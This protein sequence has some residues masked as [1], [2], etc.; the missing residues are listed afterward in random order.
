[1]FKVL[2]SLVLATMSMLLLCAE[3]A[4]AAEHPSNGQPINEEVLAI[5]YGGDSFKPAEL[6]I[7][8]VVFSDATAYP[9]VSELS[10]AEKYMLAGVTSTPWKS[11]IQLKPWSL[12]VYFLLSKYYQNGMPI[13][14]QL[15]YEA[16]RLLPEYAKV[17]DL[18]LDVYRNPMT[19]E[20]P[21]LEDASGLP[22]SVYVHELTEDEKHHLAIRD[23][24][25]KK[26]LYLDSFPSM[27][28]PFREHRDP[29]G[30]PIYMRIV[31]LSGKPI[32]EFIW[33]W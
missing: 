10:H 15:S 3:T 32:L 4:M 1:M 5:T 24:N 29:S 11:S 31:G 16:I 20:W 25:Y 2:R 7:N 13:P 26:V 23:E 21:V 28:E 19:G 17:G 6:N 33:T 12:D 27:E 9:D 14:S 8:N 30:P 22:G 18:Q